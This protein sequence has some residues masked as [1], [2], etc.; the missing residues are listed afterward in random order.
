MSPEE[1][2]AAMIAE[3]FAAVLGGLRDFPEAEIDQV[4]DLV[5]VGEWAVALENLCSQL[6]EYECAVAPKILATIEELGRE[7]GVDARYWMRL[8]AAD[9]ESG[10]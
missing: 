6:Y 3:Q 9:E 1:Q 4:K 5:R 2:R 7:I 10:S 8:A